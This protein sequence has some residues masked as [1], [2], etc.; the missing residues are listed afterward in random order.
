MIEI[1]MTIQVCLT[2]GILGILI[3]GMAIVLARLLKARGHYLGG[4]ALEECAD[5]RNLGGSWFFV[6]LWHGGRVDEPVLCFATGGGGDEPHGE[7]AAAID[8]SDE[9]YIYDLQSQESNQNHE[10]D[11]P[12]LPTAEFDD[13]GVDVPEDPVPSGD[14]DSD[15]QREPAS[16][17]GTD[18]MIV[19]MSPGACGVDETSERRDAP[20]EPFTHA[21]QEGGTSVTIGPIEGGISMDSRLIKVDFVVGENNVQVLRETMVT[22]PTPAIK[23]RNI[24]ATVTDLVAEVIPD[25]VIIQGIIHKQIFFVDADNVVRHLA[26]DVSF[27]T[28]VEIAG[29]DQG[30][31]VQ[32][33]PT[34]EHISFRL[35]APTLL[36]QKV[37]LEIFVKVTQTL[38]VEA[39]L[40][41]GP[42]IK[43]EAV[44]NENSSQTMVESCVTLPEPAVKVS[45]LIAKVRDITA[46]V[47]ED[48]VLVQG[49]VHKQIFFVDSAGVER[50]IPEDVQFSVFV[51]VPGARP[52]MN[53]EVTPE[54]EH[55]AFE[56]RDET[57]VCQ[58]VVISVLAKV[59][60]TVQLSLAL[61]V[62][63]LVKVEAVHGEA[64]DQMLQESDVTLP[65]PAEKVREIVGRVDITDSHVIRGK[66]IIQGVVHKQIFFI[67][68]DG[69][70]RHLA[71]D[72]PFGTF[73]EVP[74]AMPGQNVQVHPKIEFIGFELIDDVTVRQK[75]VVEFFVKVTE[76]VQIRIEVRPPYNQPGVLTTN[77]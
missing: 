29:A 13:V 72:V 27:S 61:G 21:L 42:L 39:V 37:V 6:P 49:T 12:S 33:I 41:N 68:T 58:K 2:V 67:G 20:S 69:L 44:V 31:N 64:T 48:K 17:T 63:P 62:G 18:E 66:V 11:L 8:Q 75:V 34:V 46:E 19:E 26:E 55:V 10:P 52:G 22:L 24:V 5:L 50:H 28:F 65:S 35:P 57:T 25:K 71:E 32:V 56:L 70:E 15:I 43:V 16:G 74:G 40:G 51:D 76:T 60:E 36:E 3:A 23:I 47:I 59:T 38:E 53:V 45:D 77:L 1:H 30:M 54:I 14:A 7:L 9:D 4:W 73:I